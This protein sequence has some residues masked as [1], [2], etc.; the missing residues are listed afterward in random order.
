[1]APNEKTLTW[2]KTALEMEE[3]GKKHY[4]QAALTSRNELGREIFKML[5]DYEVEH[6]KRIREIYAKLEGGESWTGDL[7]EFEAVTDLTGVFRELAKKQAAEKVR[8]DDVE[9]LNMGMDFENASIRFYQEQSRA[10]RDS[11]EKRFLD[12]MTLE[13]RG[14]LN[15]LAD[16]RLYYTDPEAWYIEK[17]RVHLDGA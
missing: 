11:H 2:L 9:A 16:M 10:A 8:A 14:H 13:E 1:M 17:D 5:S 12:L 6:Q 3:K 4:D 7:A 15:V